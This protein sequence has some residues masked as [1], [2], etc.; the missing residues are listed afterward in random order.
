MKITIGEHTLDCNERPA[1]MGILNLGTDSPVSHSVIPNN[2][3]IDAAAERAEALRDAGA[4]IMD[5][6]AHSTRTGGEAPTPE[7]EIERLCPAIEA[8]RREG[9]LISVDTWTAAVADAALQAGAQILN[10]VTAAADPD[11]A[12][13]AAR[14]GCPLI[15]MHMRGR[16]KAHREADQAYGDVA[17]EVRDYLAQHVDTLNAEGVDSVWIDP[18]FE[19]AKSLDDN[20]RMLAGLS[21]LA[22]LGRPIVV[23]ASR[24]G[25]LAELL[26]HGKLRSSEAQQV[27][28]ILQATIAVN[29]IAGLLGAHIVRVHDVAEI[30]AAMKV[31]AGM[32]RVQGSIEP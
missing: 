16:P 19:F 2:A 20:L 5:V 31:V 7:Q 18:G 6:G 13:V 8:L 11:M 21:Q 15:V 29:V 28:G 23:S 32:R 10:D 17:G 24:K 4:A 22:T 30:E 25:F 1:I 14:H 3:A 12:G 9:H 27:P 26:G